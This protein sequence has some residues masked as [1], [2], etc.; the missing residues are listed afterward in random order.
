MRLGKRNGLILMEK[1]GT[2]FQQKELRTFDTFRGQQ[3]LDAKQWQLYAQYQSHSSQDYVPPLPSAHLPAQGVHV[4]EPR[5]VRPGSAPAAYVKPGQKSVAV[6]SDTTLVASQAQAERIV[7]HTAAASVH[8][9]D[10][11]PARQLSSTAANKVLAGAGTTGS[12]VPGTLG[13]SPLPTRARMAARPSS[14][15]APRSSEPA[16]PGP[17]RASRA[18]KRRPAT[19]ASRSSTKQTSAQPSTRP[20]S[21]PRTYPALK[22]WVDSMKQAPCQQRQANKWAQRVQGGRWQLPSAVVHAIPGSQSSEARSLAASAVASAVIG[23]GQSLDADQR[24]AR[25]CHFITQAIATPNGLLADMAQGTSVLEAMFELP[26]MSDEALANAKAA[27]PDTAAQ[28][29]EIQAWLLSL[30]PPVKVVGRF[31]VPAAPFH[32]AEQHRA[33]RLVQA[34]LRQYFEAPA[35]SAQ[36]EEQLR[37]TLAR[38]RRIKRQAKVPSPETT[39]RQSSKSSAEWRG[40][41]AA[42]ANTTSKLVAQLKAEKAAAALAQQQEIAER[43]KLPD[44]ALGRAR[45][46]GGMGFHRVSPYH[47]AAPNFG[48]PH[49]SHSHRGTCSADVGDTIPPESVAAASE[50]ACTVHSSSLRA[51]LDALRSQQLLPE[52]LVARALSTSN[53][54]IAHAGLGDTKC[55]ALAAAL[56]AGSDELE[57]LDV[58]HNRLTD[59]SM[60]SLLASMVSLPNMK[61]LACGG[62][63]MGPT[64]FLALNALMASSPQLLRLSVR[65][66]NLNGATLSTL[67]QGLAE[68]KSLR[69]LDLSDNILP[70]A[71]IT[72]LAQLL[73]T[74]RALE[75]LQL[76]WCGLS[77]ESMQRLTDSLLENNAAGHS[78]C[79]VDVSYNNL[80]Q[81]DTA[82]HLSKLIRKH[83]GLK[84]ILAQHCSL[85]DNAAF[86]LGA[87]IASSASLVHVDLRHN[88]MG[89]LGARSLLT[90][91]V[92][93][94]EVGL[95]VRSAMVQA[96]ENIAEHPQSL[97]S[98]EPAQINQSYPRVNMLEC[99]INPVQSSIIDMSAPSG[100]HTF[101]LANELQRAQFATI[102]RG[103][104]MR[105]GLHITSCVLHE[106]ARDTELSIQPVVQPDPQYEQRWSKRVLEQEAQFRQEERKAYTQRAVAGA[107]HVM[108]T[109]GTQRAAAF[110]SSLRVKMQ[111]RARRSR[112][113]L[114]RKVM[115]AEREK[116]FA[117]RTSIACN[118]STSWTPPDAGSVELRVSYHKQLPKAWQEIPAHVMPVL[119]HLLQQQVLSKYKRFAWLQCMAQEFFFTTSQATQVVLTVANIDSC[120]RSEDDFLLQTHT[121]LTLTPALL[122]PT[123]ARSFTTECLS[124]SE[125]LAFSISIGQMYHF[126]VENPTG[127]YKLRLASRQDNKL[128]SMLLAINGK[129]L[130]E[131]KYAGVSDTSQFQD[132][133]NFRNVRLNGQAINFTQYANA[134]GDLTQGELELDFVSTDRPIRNAEMMSHAEAL[135]LLRVMCAVLRMDPERVRLLYE[136][137]RREA[138]EASHLPDDPMLA[139][140]SHQHIDVHEQL[141]TLETFTAEEEDGDLALPVLEQM[142]KDAA[143]QQQ[144]KDRER[145]ATEEAIRNQNFG[146]SAATNKTART[147]EE[148]LRDLK[149]NDPDVTEYFHPGFKKTFASW[150]DKLLEHV[151]MNL[152]SVYISDTQA[153]WIVEAVPTSFYQLRIEVAV[154]LWGRMYDV[155]GLWRVCGQQLRVPWAR[156]TLIN[157]L[158][159]LNIVDYND[160]DRF[161]MLNL[162]RPDERRCMEHLAKLAEVEPG[163]NMEDMNYS[164]VPGFDLPLSWLTEVPAF[165]TISFVY[166]STAPGC[167]VVP[168]CRAELNRDTLQRTPFKD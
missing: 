145:L 148:R 133:S 151:R 81:G 29:S 127:H 61:S 166:T 6:V 128:L 96:W 91:A 108:A 98:L 155:A 43:S 153:K 167:K 163:P 54:N 103:V 101:N 92:E 116:H 162:T 117:A 7:Q 19:A 157:R 44:T 48:L 23:P 118:G 66:S 13:P 132:Y 156:Q 76:A 34:G 146:V 90:A 94:H 72:S 106:P 97:L 161:F 77:S 137:Y 74:H 27:L 115:E 143:A 125:Q 112:R 52:S 56:A 67:T 135:N 47:T 122:D 36:T 17:V 87:S 164:D 60:P 38:L 28:A 136:G 150:A 45:A 82:M 11:T 130:Q 75:S 104:R 88:V 102:A 2:A 159:I 58:S 16:S 84:L 89:P 40:G 33:F 123:Q 93:T 35:K 25:D 59:C 63:T 168:A 85:G 124:K 86:A 80:N 21:A 50:A 37:E 100:K 26:S 70:V 8:D 152:R 22:S 95:A 15:V 78:F 20:A 99:S 158:G 18:P 57:A 41:F 142:A 14:A 9:Q 31:Q 139:S 126:F 4:V 73:R 149:A 134:G 109:T 105:P 79:I 160:A 51:Y 49:A 42:R 64:S 107:V 65:A 147:Y 1:H 32:T 141:A 119:L 46:A 5:R 62:N 71:G 39:R 121:L 114:A 131:R 12:R 144:A 53:L 110:M 138:R 83:T 129:Q 113:N 120:G 10:G 24:E 68:C 154:A 55:A 140:C 165:Q 3:H 30:C 111:L 69:H